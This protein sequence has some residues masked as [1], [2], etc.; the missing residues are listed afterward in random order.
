M[1]PCSARYACVLTESALFIAPLSF[2]LFIFFLLLP[3]PCINLFTH[4]SSFLFL[5]PSRRRK[6]YKECQDPGAGTHKN[7]KDLQL[8]RESYH[9][10]NLLWAT[11]PVSAAA[12][13]DC[14]LA[15]RGSLKLI[16]G[17]AQVDGGGGKIKRARLLTEGP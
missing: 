4:P 1:S 8:G 13:D 10:S 3:P 14:L 11:A 2:F 17:P 15:V 12:S 6:F 5:P 16:F 9:A 7:S